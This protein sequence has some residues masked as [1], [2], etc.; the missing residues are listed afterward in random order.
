MTRTAPLGLRIE[1]HV[2]EALQKAANADHRTLAAYVERL[3]IMD[4]EGKGY[5]PTSHEK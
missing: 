4:L 2:K 5:L 3:I 1:P